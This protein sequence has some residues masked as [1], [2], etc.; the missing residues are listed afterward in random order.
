[1]A[2]ETH[3]GYRFNNH[4]NT[5]LLIM[6]LAVLFVLSTKGCGTSSSSYMQDSAN[7]NSDTVN[8]VDTTSHDSTIINQ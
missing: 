3:F 4:V 2:K 1:M 8:K 5:I 6:F 7:K